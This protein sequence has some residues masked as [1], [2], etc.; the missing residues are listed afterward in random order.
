MFYTI[1]P[2]PDCISIIPVKA[3][4]C[5]TRNSNVS[6]PVFYYSGMFTK[7]DICSGYM[8]GKNLV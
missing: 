5:F 3:C 7:T 4:F 8:Q 2:R 6:R 1:N